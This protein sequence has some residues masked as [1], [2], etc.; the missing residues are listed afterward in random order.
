MGRWRFRAPHHS[1]ARGIRQEG[2]GLDRTGTE[3]AHRSVETVPQPTRYDLG[4]DVLWR[5]ETRSAHGSPPLRSVVADCREE[6][7]AREVGRWSL[8]PVSPEV[9]DRAEAPVHHGRCG[10]RGM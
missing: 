7:Q 4:L 9:G 1:V 3:I 10:G 6:G 8:A 5:A 2:E